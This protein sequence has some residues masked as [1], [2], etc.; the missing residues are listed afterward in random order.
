MLG[1][2]MGKF[3]LAD[4]ADAARRATGVNDVSVAHV[5]LLVE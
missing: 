2:E 3:A 1:M 4:L 5:G